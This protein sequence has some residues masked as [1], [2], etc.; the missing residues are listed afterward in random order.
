MA[1]QF[2]VTNME[3]NANTHT[4]WQRNECS[5]K[6]LPICFFQRSNKTYSY[7]FKTGFQFNFI[8][9]EFWYF[10]ESILMKSLHLWIAQRYSTRNF[11]KYKNNTKLLSDSPTAIKC[12]IDNKIH[13]KNAWMYYYCIECVPVDNGQRS[14]FKP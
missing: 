1:L 5:N 10:I 11:Q 6:L 14:W 13:S 4:R 9:L 2:K 3:T 8:F 12:V 7:Y